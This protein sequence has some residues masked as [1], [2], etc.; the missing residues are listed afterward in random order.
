VAELLDHDLLFGLRVLVSDARPV[1]RATFHDAR[2]R[3]RCQTGRGGEE[4][5]QPHL[6]DYTVDCDEWIGFPV[7]E[8]SCG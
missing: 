8:R 5:A 6:F 1:S 2:M 7:G 4:R 3:A